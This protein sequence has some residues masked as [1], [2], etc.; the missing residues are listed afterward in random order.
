M[1]AELTIPDAVKGSSIE[2][3]VELVFDLTR[4]MELLDDL[5]RIARER[6][7][8]TDTEGCLAEM[9][10]SERDVIVRGFSVQ[11]WMP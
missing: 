10:Q 2:Q 11:T 5:L 7:N 4:R 9:E 3:R 1:A 6:R 8:A